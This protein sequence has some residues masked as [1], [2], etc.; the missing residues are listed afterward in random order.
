LR[1]FVENSVETFVE[2]SVE[3]SVGNLVETFVESSVGARVITRFS[4]YHP[5]LDMSPISGF[6]IMVALDFI[7]TVHTTFAGTAFTTSNL[8]QTVH[9]YSKFYSI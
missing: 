8:D 7:Q 5:F 6:A 3:N 2:S 9:H 4:I 1:S